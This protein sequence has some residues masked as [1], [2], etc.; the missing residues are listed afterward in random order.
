MSALPL[1]VRTYFMT[2]FVYLNVKNL[3]S[4][5]FSIIEWTAKE[6]HAVASVGQPSR[7]DTTISAKTDEKQIFRSFSPNE[8]HNWSQTL[9]L[10]WFL[11]EA[12]K[13]FELTFD[14]QV[15]M[16]RGLH[17]PSDESLLLVPH[18]RKI[19]SEQYCTFISHLTTNRLL[20]PAANRPTNL[21]YCRDVL[22][23]RFGQC[24]RPILEL[25]AWDELFNVFMC[26]IPAIVRYHLCLL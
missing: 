13:K 15:S 26:R 3:T 5:V 4:I 6:S 1:G 25:L 8:W 17:L 10:P 14:F 9:L 21:C 2:Y 19:N 18:A 16:G 20:S 7:S 12:L 23:I 11:C 22:K 24:P